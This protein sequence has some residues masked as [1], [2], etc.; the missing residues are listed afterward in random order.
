M[1]FY[2][3]I[4]EINE[5]LKNEKLVIF[6]GAGVSKNSGIPTWGQMVRTF[7][8]KIGYPDIKLTTN[9]YIKIPQYFYVVDKSENH[10]EYYKTLKEIV[11]INCEP[12]IINKLIYKIHPKYIVT[13]NYDKLMD[14]VSTDY[15]II[16]KDK[17]LL[18]T[19]GNN[20]LI[21]MHG[22]V[23]YIREIVFKEDD[24]LQYSET[25]RL[26]EIFI[27]SLL[28]D[29]IFLFIGYS[30]NDYNLNT[31]VS[32][33]DFIAKEM[34]VKE[35]MHKNFFLSSSIQ[36]GKEYLKTYYESKGLQ[37]IDMFNLPKNVENEVKKIKLKDEIGRRTFAVLK[38][39][40]IK[41]NL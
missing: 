2:D 11:D 38:L 19:K 8:K 37:V 9:D 12:N 23:D 1:E 3:M 18:K 4:D 35:S 28:I 26:M 25:H 27:K 40:D 17:D 39:L 22:D 15:E 10:T 7:A 29:H 36:A 30:L 24:Y 34:K 33:I 20:Y 5:S 13:T 31:F 16:K 41:N 14:K 21:K 6:V 32:W